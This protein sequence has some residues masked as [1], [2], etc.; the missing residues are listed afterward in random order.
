MNHDLHRRRR[1]A[2]SPFFSKKAVGDLDGAVREKISKVLGRLETAAET[3]EVLRLEVAF[4]ALATDIITQYAFEKSWN[5]LDQKDF[6]LAWKEIMVMSFSSNGMTRQFPVFLRMIALTPPWLIKILSPGMG[7][8]LNWKAEVENDVKSTTEASASSADVKADD[9]ALDKTMFQ[10]LHQ[11]NLPTSEKTV[12]RLNDEAI[13]VVGG[14]VETVQRNLTVATFHLLDNPSILSKLRTELRSIW[15][16]PSTPADLPT[17]EHAPYLSAVISESLRLGGSTCL[18]SGR[19]APSETLTYKGWVIPPGTAISQTNCM[20]LHD[21]QIFPDP[22]VFKP[23]RWLTDATGKAD[24]RK[25]PFFSTGARSC[26]GMNLGYAELYLT[27]AE[28]FRRFD[29]DLF[30]TDRS[31]VDIAQYCMG[32]LVRM[33]S[34]GLCV[35]V[36]GRRDD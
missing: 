11:S 34:K 24:K 14:A 12:E 19:I 8:F 7:Y 13:I 31:D 22:L 21:E 16:D 3:H 27:I 5:C 1:A 30:E 6:N 17:L 2:L 33:D 9:M 25:K 10:I 18:P 29:F 28:V 4:T 23:E 32:G 26:I 36:A 15:P 20:L 35:K